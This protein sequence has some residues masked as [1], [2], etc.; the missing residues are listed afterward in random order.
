MYI[1][2][3]VKYFFLNVGIKQRQKSSKTLM[4]IMKVHAGIE[5]NR[6]IDCAYSRNYV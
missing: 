1:L 3:N 5:Y 6:T 2:H 4:G